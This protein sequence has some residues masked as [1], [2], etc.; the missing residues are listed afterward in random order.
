[1][2]VRAALSSLVEGPG[3]RRKH[4]PSRLHRSSHAEA[5]RK[6]NRDPPGS[7]GRR[8]RQ[9]D[10]GRPGPSRN[11][12]W[13]L[14][15]LTLYHSHGRSTEPF[16]FSLGGPSPTPLGPGGAPRLGSK[17]AAERRNHRV[18][19]PDLGVGLGPGGPNRDGAAK[20]VRALGKTRRDGDI[21]A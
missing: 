11:P 16:P 9:R 19:R 1:M 20:P 5:T 3:P 6:G 21:W 17:A 15:P 2:R 7:P 10:P 13:G 12:S 8:R 4:N 18:L 14:W